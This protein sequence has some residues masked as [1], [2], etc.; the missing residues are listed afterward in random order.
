VLTG[1]DIHDEPLE[2]GQDCRL[3]HVLQHLPVALM[4]SE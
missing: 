3:S 1:S 4:V 2:S